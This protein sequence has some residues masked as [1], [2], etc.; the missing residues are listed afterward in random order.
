M[1]KN[2]TFSKEHYPVLWREV[3]NY[4]NPSDGKVFVDCTFGAGGHSSLLLQN[5]AFVYAIDR[6]INNKKFADVLSEKYTDKF[7]FVNEKF[8]NIKAT[9]EKYNINK[10][11]GIL[12]DFGVSSMQI[13][14]AERG[15]SFMRDGD[16]KMQMGLNELSA[17]DVVNSFDE[18]ELQRIIR[19]YGEERY[20]KQIAAKICW[21]RKNRKPIE[22]TKELVDVVKSAFWSYH[23]KIHPATRTFQAIRIATNNELGEIEKSLHD[24][25]NMLPNG[26]VICAISFHSLEDRIVKNVFKNYEIKQKK[27]NKFKP[28]EQIISSITLEPLCEKVI[29]ASEEELRENVRSRSAKMRVAKIVNLS[30]QHFIS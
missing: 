18:L 19:D 24:A 13:D 11:D 10:C 29:T 14:D 25:I 26:C 21:H 30:R 1:Q 4:L 23:D 27:V 3:L 2:N 8:S 17:Y 16:L 5:D 28:Q 6:D 20:Y 15:F 12:Y 7:C 22:T 9:L